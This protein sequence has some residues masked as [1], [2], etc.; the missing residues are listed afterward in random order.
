M[1]D[2]SSE[3]HPFNAEAQRR[4]GA[5]EEKHGLLLRLCALAPLRFLRSASMRISI[6]TLLFFGLTAMAQAETL[7]YVSDAG[8][9]QIVVYRMDDDSGELSEVQTVDTKAAPGSLCVDPQKKYLF[10]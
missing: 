3:F 10:A 8:N 2:C 9:Q 7:L 5:G 6:L 1:R 4:K